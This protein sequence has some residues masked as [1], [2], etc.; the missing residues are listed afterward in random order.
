VT[1][2]G[3]VPLDLGEVRLPSRTPLAGTLLSI[4]AFVIRHRAGPILVDTGMAADVPE[5]NALYQPQIVPIAKALR[6]I[7]LL[8]ADIVAVVNTHLHF[9]HC[10][11]NRLFSGTPVFVQASELNAAR[12]PG[13]T[14]PEWVDFPE[15][16]YRPIESDTEIADGVRLLAAGGHTAGTQAV[17]VQSDEGPLL[18]A[19][20]AAA[21]ARE[22]E[23]PTYRHP[24][25]L[26]MAWDES[27]YTRSL[28]RLRAL[29]LT[30]VYFSHD[31]TVLR[32]SPE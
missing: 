21:D 12:E 24:R 13:Y 5:L 2:R 11:G 30:A 4:R 19:A 15:S 31:A 3:V 18:I 10:G 23:D 17:T 14:V 1:D 20:Q 28:E 26:A 6:A 29:S 25:G 7:G 22:F 16:D 27:A 8:P 32:P 9:D